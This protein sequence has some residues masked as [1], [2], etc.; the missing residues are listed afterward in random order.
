MTVKITKDRQISLPAN[1]LNRN[2]RYVVACEGG[3]SRDGLRAPTVIE[4]RPY[5]PL[6][7]Q[8][9]GIGVTVQAT[10]ETARQYISAGHAIQNAGRLATPGEYALEPLQDD[11]P[12]DAFQVILETQE[13]RREEL[14]DN[15]RFT[16][17]ILAGEAK[18][19]PEAEETVQVE[20]KRFAARARSVAEEAA[21]S[22]TDEGHFDVAKTKAWDLA[23]SYSKVIS[24]ASRCATA[25][26]MRAFA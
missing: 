15:I 9:G 21:K 20:L 10:S 18:K 16:A 11:D 17:E 23:N 5:V 24:A 8:R 2:R 3:H 6:A 25:S 14:E 26:L 19:L 4:I 22:V 13:S 12:M 1:T 7:G